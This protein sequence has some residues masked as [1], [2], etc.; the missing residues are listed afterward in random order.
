MKTLCTLL[1]LS[2]AVLPS[3]AGETQGPTKAEADLTEI[4]RLAREHQPEGAS[5]MEVKRVAGMDLAYVR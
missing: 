4:R 2:F 5:R 1:V 3:L